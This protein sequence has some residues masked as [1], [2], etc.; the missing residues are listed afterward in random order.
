MTKAVNEEQDKKIEETVTEPKEPA[1]VNTIAKTYCWVK[2]RANYII[3]IEEG[4]HSR[5][6]PPFGKVKVVR[7]EIKLKSDADACYLTFIKA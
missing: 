7:E 6:I 1:K 5:F 2:S 3:E 4:N